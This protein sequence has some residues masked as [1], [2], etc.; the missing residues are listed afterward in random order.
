MQHRADARAQGVYQGVYAAGFSAVTMAAPTLITFTAIEHGTAGRFPNE[1]ALAN[2][3]QHP[4]NVYVRE[5]DLVDPLDTWLASAFAPVQVE[6][7]RTMLATCP[8]RV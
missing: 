1:Y 2:S 6:H 4:L 5:A 7:S 3:I 8:D